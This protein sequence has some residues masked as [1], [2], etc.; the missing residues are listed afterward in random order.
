MYLHDLR[1][2]MNIDVCQNADEIKVEYTAGT[3]TFTVYP[4]NFVQ[5]QFKEKKV[6]CKIRKEICPKPCAASSMS[7][8]ARQFTQ[9]LTLHTHP[10]SAPYFHGQA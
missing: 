2:C 5:G 1:V 6:N 8:C 4:E 7:S 9:N 3:L 10:A